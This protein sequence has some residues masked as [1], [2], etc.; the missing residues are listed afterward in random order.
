MAQPRVVQGNPPREAA[1]ASSRPTL[2]GKLD[3]GPLA[4]SQNEVQVTVE[5]AALVATPR[6]SLAAQTP[7]TSVAV[8][9]GTEQANG[10]VLPGTA[11]TTQPAG[12]GPV[13]SPR[14]TGRAASCS[15]TS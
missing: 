3:F 15:D 12:F 13:S 4:G 10:T 8:A 7:L 2:T 11:A 9:V 5:R 14:A 6:L 1:K